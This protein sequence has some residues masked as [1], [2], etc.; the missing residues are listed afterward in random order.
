MEFRCVHGVDSLDKAPYSTR[1][2]TKGSGHP[3]N[4]YSIQLSCRRVR[5]E[6]PKGGQRFSKAMF[7]ERE[8][9]REKMSRWP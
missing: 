7:R 4:L 5:G 9:R 6:G 3:L 8:G 1:E 2:N